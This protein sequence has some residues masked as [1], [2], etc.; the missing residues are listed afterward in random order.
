VERENGHHG[1][2]E[3]HGEAEVVHTAGEGGGR[4]MRMETRKE[5]RRAMKDIAR[6]AAPKLKETVAEN[7]LSGRRSLTVLLPPNL[8]RHHHLLVKGSPQCRQN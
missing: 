6:I 7:S 5:R 3:A 1:A 8:P 2:R 4:G